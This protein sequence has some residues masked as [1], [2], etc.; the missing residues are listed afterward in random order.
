MILVTQVL[1]D[2]QVQLARPVL[3]V[4]LGL[5]VSMEPLATLGLL[6]QL[7]QRA[8]QESQELLVL[9]V[10]RVLQVLSVLLA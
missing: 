2:P 10:L 9:R 6:E 5:Q 1:Q 4:L 7:A 8:Q 3:R